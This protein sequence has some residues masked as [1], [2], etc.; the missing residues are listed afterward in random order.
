MSPKSSAQPH[1]ATAHS[2][3]EPKT[4]APTAHQSPHGPTNSTTAATASPPAPHP[5]SSPDKPPQ[6]V[7]QSPTPQP[8]YHRIDAALN[9]GDVA[10]YIYSSQLAAEPAWQAFDGGT[11]LKWSSNST[12][13]GHI[14][15]KLKT[16]KTAT[17]YTVTG[18]GGNQDPSAWTFQG[19][20]DGSAWT[21]LDTRS[22]ITFSGSTPQ[23][24]SFSNSTGYTYYRLNIT[25][26]NGNGT[27]VSLV[28]LAITGVTITTLP[29]TAEIWAVLYTTTAGG[30]LNGLWSMNRGNAA[31]AHSLYPYSGNVYEPFGAAAANTIAFATST[32]A[33]NNGSWWLYRVTNDGTNIRTYANNVLANTLTVASQGGTS[34]P[35][36]A[37]IGSGLYS[38]TTTIPWTG[39]IAE[40]YAR[41]SI[42][43]ST[44]IA[45]MLTYFNT[46]HGLTVT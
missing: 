20:N 22:S 31:N 19:S 29:T 34:W 1:S 37:L 17:E 45:N 9:A 3:S 25:A 10:S 12:T 7:K 5:P 13:T 18:Y 35:H 33:I 39:R 8:R 4:T 28:E 26:N 6:T 38:S 23:A 16:A 2:G 21:T 44:D 32:Y 43:D 41:T 46:E 30:T 27:F 36:R 42:S 14:G 11:S 24:F 40:V 15:V